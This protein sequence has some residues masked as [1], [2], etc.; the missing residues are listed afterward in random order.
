MNFVGV[1]YRSPTN[2]KRVSETNTEG[3]LRNSVG[4]S[5][6]QSITWPIAPKALNPKPLNPKPLNPKPLNP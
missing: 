1:E 3:F 5:S 6:G 4:N 2:F